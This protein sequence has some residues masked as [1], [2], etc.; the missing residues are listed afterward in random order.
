MSTQE[1]HSFLRKFY[2]L[3]NSGFSAH[4]GIH[5][6]AGEAWV[7]L[8]AKLGRPH[9]HD[10]GPGHHYPSKRVSPS[11]HRRRARRA[12]A[13]DER[14]QESTII[15]ENTAEKVVEESDAVE[16]TTDETVTEQAVKAS[17]TAS[18]SKQKN[19]SRNNDRDAEKAPDKLM[20]DTDEKAV[21]KVKT[22]FSE[23]YRSESCSS[24]R[25]NEDASQ[26]KHQL[27][28]KEEGFIGPRLPRMLTDEE[29]KAIFDRLLGDKY[30]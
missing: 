24:A 18:E 8:H 9:Q 23:E 17:K 22:D 20:N 5:C 4:L 19:T 15:E 7:D 30:K 13:R 14:A 11:R 2:Q 3:W 25:T 10:Q 16:N 12:A 1:F 21:D 29:V 6:H 28:E 27:E 26:D